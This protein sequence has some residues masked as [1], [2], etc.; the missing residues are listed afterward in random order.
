MHLTS[1]QLNVLG[2]IV[3]GN[4]TQNGVFIPCDLDQIIERVEYK[5]TK[6][7]IHFSIR[8][9]IRKGLIEKVSTELRRD[10]RRVIIAPTELGRSSYN[11]GADLSYIADEDDTFGVES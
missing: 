7:A 1:K 4:G 8:N 10:R 9:L 6:A 2:V 3:N 11:S 5:P